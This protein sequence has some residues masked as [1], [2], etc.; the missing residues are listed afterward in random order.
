MNIIGTTNGTDTVV[1]EVVF[2]DGTDGTTPVN[3]SKTDWGVILAIK[4]IAH[5]GTITVSETSGSAA[6]KALATGTNS[7]GVVSVTGSS[8]RAF[9]KAPT[10]VSD[11]A[12]TKQIGLGGTSTAYAADT[13]DS[14]ALNGATAQTMNTAF[15]TVTEIY[16]GDLEAAR[17]ITLAVGAADDYQLCA[18]KAG[19]AGASAKDDDVIV[20]I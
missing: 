1:E 7:A 17:T 10:I 6:I 9:N 12:T 15:N 14:Q 19:P 4:T 13:Y 20:I 2:T 8:Q 11:S 16:V 5:A 3:S 18:G